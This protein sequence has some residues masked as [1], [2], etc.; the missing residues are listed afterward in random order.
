[1]TAIL[2]A[3][4]AVAAPVAAPTVRVTVQPMAAP[5]PALKYQFLP[6]I[7][8]LKAGNAAQWYLRSFMEQRSF[9]FSKEGTAQRVRYQGMTLKELASEPL[10]NYGGSALTQTDWGARLDTVD[11]QVLDRIQAEGPDLR[12]PELAPLHLLAASLQIRFRVEVA[13]GEYDD[14]I[15]TAKT[16]F[17]LARHLSDY[18]T[19]A[20]NRIGLTI[21]DMTLDTLWEMI[22]QPGCPNLY[23]ALTDLPCPLVEL[24]KG[25]QGDRALV[26]TELRA[27]RDNSVL[28]DTEV[29]DLVSRLSGRA[30]Y[31]REQA[32]LP[33]RNLRAALAARAK[34]A[35]G[36]RDA[37]RRLI[38]S[39]LGKNA[40]E[41]FDPVH[42]VL[43]D[44]KRDY[45]VRRDEEIRLL[46]VKAWEMDAIPREK[47]AADGLFTDLV[48][49]IADTRR[50]QA[51]FEQRVAL[52]RHVEALRMFAAAH[53]G[54][55]PNKLDD[56]GVP[57]PV[58][59]FT[60]KPFA[61]VLEGGVAKL[62]GSAPK[63]DGHA[64]SYEVIVQ[65]K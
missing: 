61:Y 17:A 15:R 63:R 25:V 53:D 1:M 24:R 13:R 8:E 6:E 65:K 31:I 55:L 52:L 33:P 5:K 42:V 43:L 3:A 41:G 50:A 26:D 36:V 22:Q 62:R 56:A 4:A 35:T 11:W 48:P 38:E 47:H 39:G 59:P 9:F 12:L 32:G 14:A 34:D 23:W 44:D 46:G 37:R 21:A 49:R 20:A 54:K 2:L 57:L 58:D 64:L 27:F 10:S 30:G 16:M 7:R 51:R 19:T 29:E 60:G 45:E 18:P 28:A 40:V